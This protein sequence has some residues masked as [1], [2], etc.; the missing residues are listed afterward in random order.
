MSETPINERIAQLLDRVAKLTTADKLKP[1]L[2]DRDGER[3]AQL[4]ARRDQGAASGLSTNTAKARPP[5][6]IFQHEF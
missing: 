5:V 1:T 3:H 6:R 4:I 2:F